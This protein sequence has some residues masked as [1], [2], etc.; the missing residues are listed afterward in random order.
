MNR[1][2]KNTPYYSKH[3]KHNRAHYRVSLVS[4]CSSVCLFLNCSWSSASMKR[5]EDFDEAVKR[6][7]EEALAA[8]AG[9]SKKQRTDR[10]CWRM[11]EGRHMEQ[12]ERESTAWRLV[13]NLKAEGSS[14]RREPMFKTGQNVIQWWA[15]WFHGAQEFP[16]KYG[17]K[18][19]PCWYFSEVLAVCGWG[20]RKYAGVEVEDFLYRIH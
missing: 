20:K 8:I 14:A 15:R 4:S 17:G 16:A 19:R 7:D 13:E 3:C 12:R 11:A 10:R 9:M 6:R 18:D 2:I 1:T 5:Q